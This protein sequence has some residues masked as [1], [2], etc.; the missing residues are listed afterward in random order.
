MNTESN[1]LWELGAGGGCVLRWSELNLISH[2]TSGLREKSV[3][4]FSP[5]NCGYRGSPNPR[6]ADGH[7]RSFYHACVAA[8]TQMA[9]HTGWVEFR[10]TRPWIDDVWATALR[11]S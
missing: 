6:Q 5:R 11:T 10:G 9:V 8:E 4:F 1:H 3:E 2:L 7:P